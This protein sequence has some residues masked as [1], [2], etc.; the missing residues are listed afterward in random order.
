LVRG[1]DQRWA[2][3]S[4]SMWFG[5]MDWMDGIEVTEKEAD[6]KLVKFLT[7]FAEEQIDWNQILP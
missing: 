6:E 2:Y 3:A 1:M 5:K 4:V 7:N